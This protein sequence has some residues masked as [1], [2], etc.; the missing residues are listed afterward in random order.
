MAP[1]V[2]P[3][4]AVMADV[5]RRSTEGG[6][7]SERF[8]A[9]VVAARERHPIAGYNPMTSKPVLETV[10]ALLAVDAEAVVRD[11]AASVAPDADLDLFVTVA[12]PG[13]WT[14]RFA[15]EVHHRL[16]PPT[17]Q[18]LLWTGGDASDGAVRREAIAQV[19]RLVRPPATTVRDLARREGEAYARGGLTGN[20]HPLVAEALD[21][22]GDDEGIGTAAALL[23]GDDVAIALGWTPLGLP[24]LAG[25]EHAIAVAAARLSRKGG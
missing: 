9:Y 20:P 5:Y 11:A 15:T 6:P 18:V 8:R 19:V 16:G 17:G 1:R 14:D 24:W 13:M 7:E 3:T 10:E 12:T 22:V 23:Y 21:V 4:L 25:Y 2:V